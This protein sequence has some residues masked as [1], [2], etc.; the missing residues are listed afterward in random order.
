MVGLPPARDD[1]D[2]LTAARGEFVASLPRRIEVLRAGLAAL[3]EA[4]ADRDRRNGLL[5]RLH[6]LSSAA[7]VLGFA[8]VAEVLSESERSLRK[9][10]Q[11]G[12]SAIHDVS[13]ALDVL[14]SLML[15]A[16][17]SPT[18]PGSVERAPNRPG[19]M[20]VLLYGPPSL[21]DGLDTEAGPGFE[22][23]RA[24]EDAARAL[25]LARSV[26]PDAVVVDA[27]RRGARELVEGVRGDDLIAPV[28]ILVVGSFASTEA[29]AGYVAAGADRVLP[30][31]VSPDTLR[32]ALLDVRESATQVRSPREPVGELSVEELAE[33]IAVEMKKGL[34]DSVELGGKSARISF[35]DGA[36]VLGAVWGAVARVRE[37]VTLRSG[38]NVRFQPVGPEGAVPVAPWMGEE[39][40]AGERGARS[41]RGAEDVALK[42]RRVVVAD[43]DPAVVWFLGGLLKAVGAEVIEAHDGQRA[44]ERTFEVWPDLV[45]SDVLMPQRDGFSLC[46]EIKRDVVVRD[47][48]VILLS[49]KEDLLQRVRELGAGADGYLRKEAAASTV[50]ERVREVLRPRARIEQRLRVGGEVRGR[51]DGLTP[52][53]ILE[54]SMQ[55]WR[56]ATLSIRDAVY[57][58]EVQVRGG[59]LKSL[60]RSSSDGSFERGP[61]VL[62]SLLG[63]SAGRFVVEPNSAPCRTEFDAPLA[64]LLDEPVRRAR[65]ALVA[66]SAQTLPHVV[67]V[68]IDLDAIGGYLACT[69][70]SAKALIERLSDGGSP[71]QM[72]L[73]GEVS[74]LLLEAVLSDL[75]RRGAIRS[76]EHDAA[77]LVPGGSMRA[78]AV[79]AAGSESFDTAEA[80]S[81]P[82]PPQ[83][84]PSPAD[85]QRVAAAAIES[86]WSEPPAAPVGSASVTRASQSGVTD[87]NANTALAATV[88]AAAVT[89]GVSASASEQTSQPLPHSTPP[90]DEAEG[91][92]S[93]QVDPTATRELPQVQAKV[94]AAAEPKPPAEQPKAAAAA[95]EPSQAA[96][97]EATA[98]PAEAKKESTPLGLGPTQSAQPPTASTSDSLEGLTISSAPPPS[99]AAESVQRPGLRPVLR[100]D[101]V[102]DRSSPSMADVFAAALE[103]GPPDSVPPPD[104]VKAPVAQT[105]PQPSVAEAPTAAKAAQPKAPE[106]KAP[107]PAA[108]AVEPAP[109]APEPAAASGEEPESSPDPGTVLMQEPLPTQSKAPV[110]AKASEK[111]EKLPVA[112]SV[113]SRPKEAEPKPKEAE[114]K[115]KEAEPKAK[116]VE[117]RAKEVEP[118]QPR[119]V[120]AQPRA[121]NRSATPTP[122]P[123]AAKPESEPAP[124]AGESIGRTLVLV[125]VAFV[126]AFLLVDRVIVPMLAPREQIAPTP[127]PSALVAATRASAAPPAGPVLKIEELA[128]PAG[129]DL[130]ANRGLIDIVGQEGDALYVDNTF[131]GRGPG[132]SVPV[133]AGRHEVRITRGDSVQSTPLELGAGKRL[134]V[135]LPPAARPRPNP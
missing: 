40:R 132:R 126:G 13:R 80:F 99:R 120:A 68:D 129:V 127:P 75:A 93:F 119:S 26:G 135:S 84:V 46:H 21:A 108:K 79:R 15:G 94:A 62:M 32:R 96:P 66:L 28:A 131:V 42:G 83:N 65:Q 8:S 6:A 44:L 51:L 31:P 7:R 23:T 123:G 116:D 18:D 110:E 64:E 114:P 87:G 122:P 88:A 50:I 78:A 52:R 95:P 12:G 130:G 10:G 4:P 104:S 45:V 90:A 82:P 16:P 124:V 54:L 117:A 34:T 76:V 89:T 53:L 19:P 61:K 86:A 72:L 43:D 111:S 77:P 22:L 9:T 47:V 74:A 98:L 35:G 134:R 112:A 3:A 55:A 121:S 100:L 27:D 101:A 97:V 38:G 73:T 41:G 56:D 17:L 36:D 115:P 113:E 128:I 69:P 71:R 109:K 48:P 105:V 70:D 118:T 5:R 37:L 81:E 91:W 14:P 20:G 33:R 92:F 67:G 29:A 106:P 59:R 25:T 107:E 103:E 85:A 63:V 39:R 49:W 133:T 125:V 24:D 1:E 102:R 57:L 58:Y 30:K 2:K 11:P 60:T